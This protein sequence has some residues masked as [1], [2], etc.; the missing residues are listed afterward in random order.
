MEGAMKQLDVR[1]M[2]Y[3]SAWRATLTQRCSDERGEGVIS[4]ALAVLIVA[5]LGLAAYKLFNTLIAD[6]GAKAQTQINSYG[7]Q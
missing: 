5:F 2:A 3:V 7:G 6:S 4:T 1:L